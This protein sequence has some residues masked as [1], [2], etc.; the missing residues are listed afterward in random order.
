MTIDLLALSYS[1]TF[2]V[3]VLLIWVAV[4]E[5][6][7][8]K[9]LRGN[10]GKSLEGL[11]TRVKNRE[12]ELTHGLTELTKALKRLE[13]TNQKDLNKVGVVKF[14]AFTETGGEQSFAVAILDREGTGVLLSNLYTRERTS[15][16]AK[17]ITRW[18]T[19]VKLLP[20]E[21]QAIELAKQQ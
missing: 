19:T 21:R 12:E 20:E 16:Y 10:D 11:I 7:L 9:F 5:M 1:I 18:S 15:V 2:L 8:K 14:N 3:I 13:K 4:L 6:R 17:E